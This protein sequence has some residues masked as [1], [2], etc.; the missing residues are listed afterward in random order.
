MLAGR[1]KNHYK[2]NVL[3]GSNKVSL[4]VL[5]K[6][7]LVGKT[8]ALF[9]LLLLMTFFVSVPVPRVSAQTQYVVASPGEIN[10]GMNT[11]ITVTAP[12][13]GTYTI[14]VQKPSG[15]EYKVNETLVSS[16]Q[17]QTVTFGNATSGFNGVVDQVGTYNVFIEQ[18]TTLVSST[19]FYATN[20]IV[21]AMDMVNGGNCIYV[22]GVVRGEKMF[23]RFTLTYASNGVKI[24]NTDT[25]I[26][27][28]YT[29]PSGTKANASLGSICQTFRRWSSAELELHEYWS[30]EPNATVSDADGNTGTF[31]YSG[32]PFVIS[33]ATLSTSVTLVHSETNQTLGGLA[34]GISVSIL[35]LINY[36][37][38]AEPVTGFVAPLDVTNRGGS[39]TALVG[40]GYYNATSG[41]FGGVKNAG[42]EIAL[43]K[44]TYTGKNGLWEGNFS[45]TSIPALTPGTAYE[46]VVSSKDGA[47]P[48]NTGL[49][50]LQVGVAAA[51]VTT[52]SS[53]SS[54]SSSTTSTSTSL[55]T[56]P[57]WAY[58]GTTIALIIG[59][60]V[61]FLARKPSK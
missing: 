54:T 22:Q 39:V 19:S 50:T 5:R 49:T 18:G 36:P 23:P 25:G 57:L 35:A 12:A 20:K 33:P 29:T 26:Y 58:A 38:N 44:M 13:A 7:S 45:S 17:S 61:G 27:V 43:V 11:S 42:G 53:S 40:W 32:S 1:L 55:A 41:T 2:P 52:N 3:G 47:N 30:M 59:V 16:G 51:Q 21:V 60:I 48:P 15:A 34:N 9:G 31:H 37:T 10:F 4:K 28:T 56:I 24:T 8:S 14:V 6:D 46:I